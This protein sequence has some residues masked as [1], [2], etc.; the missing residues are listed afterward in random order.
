MLV[1]L[2]EFADEAMSAET[3]QPSLPLRRSA[4]R[5]GVATGVSI[6]AG[7]AAAAIAGAYLA[8]KFG[9]NAE[10]DGFLAAYGVY[11]VIVLAAQAFRLVIVPDLTRA[12]A[13]DRLPAEFFS[14]ASVLLTLAAPATLV[15]IVFAGPI[16]DLLTGNLPPQAAH[17]ASSAI[18]W[19]VPAAFAQTLAALAASAL[20]AR[21]SYI[22]AAVAYALGAISGLVVFVSFAGSHGLVSL[23]WGL[24]LNGALAIG[25]PF[26]ALLRY[27]HLLGSRSGQVAIWPRLRKLAQ[28]AAV[29]IAIQALYL[30]AL[31]GASGLGEGNQT[32]L[33]YAY[34]F[35]ATLVAAT[36]SSLSLI[37]SAPL[38]RRG[39]DADSASA[40][41][42]HASWLS[43]TLIGAAAG[44]FT[45]VGGRVV[46]FVLGDAF[47]GEVGTDLGHLVV[48]LAPWV[49]ASVAFSVTFPLLF[50]LERTRILVPLAAVAVAVDIPLS[51]GFRELLDLRGLVLALALATL[52]VELALL[53]AVSVRM[54]V[55][56]LRGLV[57]I[58]LF[59]S[60]LTVAAFGVPD[61]V[62][63]GFP[64]AVVGFAVYVAALAAL[65]P[66]G[67]VEA[68]RYVR[69]LH[70]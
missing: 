17:V 7:S 26:V 69:V 47:A 23:A 56:T 5:S 51:L 15:T 62:M 31:R 16:G 8:H 59:V 34:L 22:V 50:V 11:L 28:A 4:L 32:S 41:V 19:V 36:A 30:I 58:A 53:A 54:L 29:P 48:Y 60:A 42:L 14:Y 63:R 55:L 2:F 68:W 49:A 27:G 44:V 45:L 21:D 39:L 40:H 65:R 35:A 64:A 43:L 38:T 66:R 37:S 18:V 20:A 10:T 46:S 57:R 9:R 24:A 3:R 12:A 1:C 61:L 6:L 52:L 67:L 70:H 13:D 33:T 25:I